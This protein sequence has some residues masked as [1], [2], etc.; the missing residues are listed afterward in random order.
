MPFN[1]YLALLKAEG[2]LV[3]VG[4]PEAPISLK[5][6]SLIFGRKNV[7]GSGIGSPDEIR[8]ML[9]LAADKQIKPW[10][11]K[12]PM[13]DA[14]QAIIDLDAGKPR[15]RYVLVNDS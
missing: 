4:V 6:F 9:Q 12:R 14:N 13:S 15:F 1:E 7:T 5:P 2:T 10:V 8:D 11:E 3:Q